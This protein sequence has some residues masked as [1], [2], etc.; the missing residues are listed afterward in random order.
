MSGIRL[1]PWKVDLISTLISDPSFTLA[2][3]EQ[4]ALSSKRRKGSNKRSKVPRLAP[5]VSESDEEFSPQPESDGDSPALP[6][7]SP[8][9]ITLD[10]DVDVPFVP[11]VKSPEVSPELPLEET[12]APVKKLKK[13]PEKKKSNKS[14]VQT[15]TPR[16]SR[17]SKES[18]DLPIVGNPVH[19]MEAMSILKQLLRSGPPS[20]SSHLID[21]ARGRSSMVHKFGHH[22]AFAKAKEKGISNQLLEEVLKYMIRENIVRVGTSNHL[23]LTEHKAQSSPSI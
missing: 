12:C 11:V 7:S 17:A 5:P 13:T 23:E 3:L 6:E 10:D 18:I 20:T 8:E 22:P 1:A 15:P 9:V 2:D 16:S 4:L 21:A 19:I 14:K